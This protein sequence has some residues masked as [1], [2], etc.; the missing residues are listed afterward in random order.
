[1]VTGK[2][3]PEDF[4]QQILPVLGSR[5]ELWLGWGA[6]FRGTILWGAIFLVPLKLFTGFQP[7]GKQAIF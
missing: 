4:P 1:M 7:I 2:L 5:F 6:I 3:P